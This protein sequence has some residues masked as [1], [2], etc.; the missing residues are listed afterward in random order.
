M[1]FM[2]TFRVTC[3]PIQLQMQIGSFPSAGYSQNEISDAT[4][5]VSVS[6]WPIW[7]L[8]LASQWY[9]QRDLLYTTLQIDEYSIAINSHNKTCQ[10]VSMR[11]SHTYFIPTH[12]KQPLY[13][14]AFYIKCFDSCCTNSPTVVCSQTILIVGPKLLNLLCNPVRCVSTLM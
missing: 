10:Y 11:I 8:Q 4:N 3:R 1:S 14:G 12:L 5:T 2:T 7:L 13:L 6:H 9:H